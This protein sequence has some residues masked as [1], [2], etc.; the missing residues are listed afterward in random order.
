MTIDGGCAVAAMVNRVHVE[1][2]DGREHDAL[3]GRVAARRPPNRQPA[4][5]TT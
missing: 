1:S 5:A 2:P 4:R 3:A